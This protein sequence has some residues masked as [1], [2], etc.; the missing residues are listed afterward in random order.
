M[1]PT[2]A[3][4]THLGDR[5]VVVSG[6][7][8][9]SG[10][11]LTDRLVL[12]CAHVVKTGSVLI[13]HPALPD[14]IRATVTWIDYRLDVA[15]LEATEPVR[16]VP[17]VR[18]GVLDTREAI[19]GCEITGF[20]R[21][22]R[23]GPDQRLEV[24]HYTATVLPMA[25]RVRDLLVCDLDGPP[26]AG[27]DDEPPALSGLSGGP[28]FAGDVLLGIARQVP[29][30]REGR[31]VECVPLG[32]ILAAEPF[33]QAYRRTGAL[34]RE[35]RVH[36]N[37]P[38][39]LRY[40]AE[41]AQA[42]GA[43]YRRTK[44]FGLD[45][46]SRHD[47]EWD[48]DTAY[49]SL[50]AQAQDRTRGRATRDLGPP[51]QTA[52]LPQRI[53]TLL[54]D[55][56]RVLLRGDAGAGK[57]TLLWWLAAHAS[58]RTLPDDLAPLNGLIPFVV[59]LRSL[60]A[61]G[62]T[63]PGPA[64]LSNV[65]GLVIDRAP[66]GWAGRV[67]ASGRAL[68]LV[69]GLDEVPPEDREQ[70][71]T[72]LSQLLHRHPQTRCV[73]TV[74][75]LAVES[76]WLR[77]DGF[78]ELRLLPMRNEDIQ[79]FVA[80]WHRAARLSEEDDTHRLDELEGDLSRQFDQN[81]TLRDLARTPLLCAVICA[82]HRRR[83]GLLPET[84]WS[85]YRSTLEMLLGHRDRIRRIDGPE[86]IEL[87]IEEHA[88]LLQRIAVW[89][90]REGQSEFTRDQA[91]RQIRRAL[92]GME[93]VSAQ[94]RPETI[95]THLLNRSGLLQRNADDAYQFI[96]RTFQDYL[97]A[98]E[99]V[100][101][102]HL[103]EMLRHA[104]EES[105]HDVILLAA[106]HCGRNQLAALVNGLL[107]AGRKHE[108]GRDER[109]TVHVLAAL[110]AQ[111]ATYL[112]GSLRSRVRASTAALFPPSTSSQVRSLAR[113]GSAALEFLPDPRHMS[114]DTERIQ[115]VAELIVDIGG[116][117]AVPHA[118]AWVLA[119]PRLSTSFAGTWERFPPEEYATEVLAQCELTETI[120]S[121]S[122]RKQLGALR[123]LPFLGSL[124]LRSDL[125][126][127]E[128]GTALEGSRLETLL[129]LKNERL[130]GVRYLSA[131]AESLEWLGISQCPG[132][133]DLGPLAGLRN[134]R[135]LSLDTREL[136]LGELAPLTELPSLSLLTLENL[137]A[138]RLIEIAAHP[139]VTELSLEN[140]R[141]LALDGLD[142]WKSL[143]GLRVSELAAFDEALTALRKH[144][145]LTDL[146][147]PAFPWAYR[148][149]QRVSAPGIRDLSVQ[150][151]QSDGD[152][153][154]LRS[155]FPGVARLTL[156]ASRRSAL[157]LTPLHAWTNLRVRVTGLPRARLIGA[158]ELGDRLSV[159][160][161]L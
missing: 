75:P 107:D 17:P 138:D 5:T 22:Q 25:G 126:E 111:Y 89:L 76:D 54:T 61:R 52:P 154:M 72:W 115:K 18:L 37:F 134:L 129:L 139:G 160:R 60:R 14:R 85:L 110:C 44:I 96:H 118:S 64:E 151:P 3:P 80:S 157:D 33:V 62:G 123:H 145:R 101:D 128:I 127:A 149:A 117:L 130:T 124:Q 35:E 78:T 24:D 39:D 150:A 141:P 84:R 71:H 108:P 20:P 81:P 86:G 40:E 23:Y 29:Q 49:L 161:F 99:L 1:S 136:R 133:R 97:S 125:P 34:L 27:P 57:T 153:G 93:R 79:A 142:A 19:P 67:L 70:A 148:P 30:Q 140:V 95:L 74:R 90:V 152:L 6:A 36:G 28:V 112:D 131:V 46:L 66:E 119:H 147:L 47:S 113:L 53:D 50:E 45:E 73:T 104:D 68:L 88:Q 122:S 21:V 11:L 144:P 4:I 13:A 155:L 69:D 143:T 38:R 159:F 16:A 12:T 121:V 83:E 156:N 2:P 92:A 114:G 132:V 10:V 65:A 58:A 158:E 7:L 59:P 135:Y 31:R 100:E 102:E 15:L 87:D 63:L 106:G 94:G 137:A 43:K 42:L 109:T 103:K 77:S 82:L 98:K 48:L 32:P 8:Q 91:L 105:W 9:G 51:D 116:A 26:A 41:Y 146:H 55:R 56:P 120:L